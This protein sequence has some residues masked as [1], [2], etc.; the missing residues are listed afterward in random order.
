VREM[1]NKNY[2]M[3]R[4]T[5]YQQYFFRCK[6]PQDLD[7]TFSQKEFI[8]SL[9]TNSYK[10]CKTLSMNLHKITQSIFNEVR[11]G[12]MKDITL[13]DVKTIL[14]DKVRHTLKHIQLYEWETNKWD[15]RELQKR[16]NEIDNKEEDLIERLQNDFKGTTEHL[17]KEVDRILKDKELKPDKKNFEYRGLISRWTD[18]QVIRET[19]KREL[20]KGERKN[21]NE[22]L[23]ELEDKCKN[24]LF[25]EH[26]IPIMEYD[27]DEPTQPYLVKSNSIEV[28][29]N[30]VSETPTP[31]CQK[32]IPNILNE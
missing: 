17:A 26:P 30:K 10:I 2:L 19:W 24:K 5:P 25:G 22:Y 3:Q 21:D 1:S 13:E 8:V 31:Y 16:I 15:E 6:I 7:K 14:R 9:K 23:E 11:E 27:A 18:L 12:Y 32:C 4:K 28:K 20:L 29:Y